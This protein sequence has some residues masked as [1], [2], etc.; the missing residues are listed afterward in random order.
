MAQ[1]YSE[2]SQELI[3]FIWKQQMFFVA[4][5]PADGYVNLSPKGLDSLRILD[6]NTVV[7]LNVTGSGNESA[8]HVLEN[9]RMTIMFCA[10]E[11]KPMILRLYGKAR[12]IHQRDEEWDAM[13]A[14]FDGLAG[15][16]QIFVL[17]IEL[18][19]T[20]CGMGVPLFDYHGQR[21]QLVEWAEKKGPD[22]LEEYW[23]RK[24]QVSLDG[25]PTGIFSDD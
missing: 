19:L 6:P 21:Q 3:Q 10:F 7:W 24:N 23:E 11:G 22:G 17:D 8:A 12:V 2:L 5:A 20:S 14:H 9:G 16:R 13:F 25:K 1:R 4:T 15:A 18:A